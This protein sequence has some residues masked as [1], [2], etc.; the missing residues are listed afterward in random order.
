MEAFSLFMTKRDSEVK[1]EKHFN[2]EAK[3]IKKRVILSIS[4]N[5]Y[6]INV[7]PNETKIDFGSKSNNISQ[8]NKPL[9]FLFDSSNSLWILEL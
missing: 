5:K 3:K 1:S 4:K 7:R 6:K 9:L 8:N 2:N